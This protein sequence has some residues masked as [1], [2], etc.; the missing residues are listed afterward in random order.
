MYR[1]LFL[2][3]IEL[4]EFSTQTHNS[5]KLKT[6]FYVKMIIFTLNAEQISEPCRFTESD[7]SEH[8]MHSTYN[9]TASQ[10]HSNPLSKKHLK[11]KIK[12]KKIKIPETL[13]E[14]ILYI[15]QSIYFLQKNKIKIYIY[16]SIKSKNDIFDINSISIKENFSSFQDVSFKSGIN[17]SDILNILFRKNLYKDDYFLQDMAVISGEKAYTSKKALDRIFMELKI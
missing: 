10:K 1:H 16:N 17:I 15:N 11:H 9:N 14:K 7:H 5:M 4:P 3:I 6:I 12:I 2:I 8:I 13:I